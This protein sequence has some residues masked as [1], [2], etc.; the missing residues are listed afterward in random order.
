VTGELGF[1]A[2]IADEERVLA[3]VIRRAAAE[4]VTP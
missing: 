2:R 1:L 4:L 3:D